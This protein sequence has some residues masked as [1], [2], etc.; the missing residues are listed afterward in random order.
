MHFRVI[1]GL[2]IFAGSSLAA[3]P[4]A[5]QTPCKA[6]G[7]T[8]LIQLTTGNVGI[9]VTGPAESVATKIL[10]AAGV[11]LRWSPP[12]PSAE[13]RRCASLS[14]AVELDART[15][16]GFHPR[17]WGYAKP[18]ASSGVRIHVFW[19]RLQMIREEKLL[20]PALGH[21]LAHEITHVLQQKL[22]HSA[23][24]LMK[25]DWGLSDFYGM[26]FRPLS[27]SADDIDLIHRGLA[28]LSEAPISD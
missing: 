25:A 18:F 21:V 28:A 8:V 7:S 17:S 12:R 5:G 16:S 14:I 22:Q 11:W 4:A 26:T 9:G 23:E 19:D 3:T 20:G 6:G 27:L 13:L 2:A 15:P 24:G 10:S 1:T